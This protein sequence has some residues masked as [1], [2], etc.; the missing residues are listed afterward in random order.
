V[1]VPGGTG[2]QRT[3]SLNL[4]PIGMERPRRSL[5]SVP[6]ESRPN[7]DDIMSALCEAFRSSRGP[8]E[9]LD[10]HKG[11]PAER[12]FEA[13]A[14]WVRKVLSSGVDRANVELDPEKVALLVNL[15]PPK[16][17]HAHADLWFFELGEGHRR[18]GPK[19]SLNVVCRKVWLYESGVPGRVTRGH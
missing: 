8:G 11:T 19:Y 6:P 18:T 1:G 16:T 2:G 10:G 3:T 12:T 7:P 13:G 15:D 9:G 5:V 17:N 14:V 4:S